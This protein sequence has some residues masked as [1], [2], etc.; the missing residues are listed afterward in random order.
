ELDRLRETLVAA[1]DL[2]PL[3]PANAP[4]A[5]LGD[6]VEIRRGIPVHQLAKRGDF[7]VHSPATLI[8]REKPSRYLAEDAP[9]LQTMAPMFNAAPGD[10]LVS[11]DGEVGLVHV[12][13]EP[14]FVSS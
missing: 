8:R 4:R 13:T 11:L 3:E 1:H 2:A 6:L 7:V 9:E 14:I 12:V 10:V 5:A